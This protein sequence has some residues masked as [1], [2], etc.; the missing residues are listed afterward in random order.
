[1]G[2]YKKVDVVDIKGIFFVLKGGFINVIIVK[3]ERI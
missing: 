1:M 3:V 2:I